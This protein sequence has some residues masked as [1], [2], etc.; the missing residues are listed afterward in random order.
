MC[1][2]FKKKTGSYQG[3]IRNAGVADIPGQGS[4]SV[5]SQSSNC[6]VVLGRN[7]YCS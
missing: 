5:T 6:C 7:Q 4:P 2:V 3:I 1:H